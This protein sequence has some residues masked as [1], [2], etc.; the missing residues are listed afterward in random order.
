MKILEAYQEFEYAI[1]IH[2]Q[3]SAHTIQA[4]QKDAYDYIQYVRLAGIE[5]M[6][7]LSPTLI[8]QYLLH[9]AAAWK[10]TTVNRKIVSIRAFHRYI[11]VEHSHV[12]DPTITIESNKLGVSLPTYLSTKEVI[13]IIECQNNPNQDKNLYERCILELLYG[14]GLRVSELCKIHINHLHLQDKLLKVVGKGDK[15]RLVVLNDISIQCLETYIYRVRSEWNIHH[16]SIL[17]INQYGRKTTRQA[18]DLFINRK[19]KALN[20][21]KNISAHTFRHAYA[22]HLLEGGADLRSVQELLGHSSI[23]TTQIYTHVQ[24]KQLKK[25]YNQAHPKYKG[26]Q[27][28]DL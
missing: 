23:T 25:A 15:E 17:F 26:K 11:S 16:S 1:H 21:E 4:Y 12:L 5:D 2:E 18:I 27:E 13:S 10:E 6:N 9:H 14:C 7:E 8:E 24:L 20:I 19:V 22:T 3:K 28:D